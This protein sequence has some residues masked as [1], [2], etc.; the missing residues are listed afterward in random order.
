MPP[1][2]PQFHGVWAQA[3]LD[4]PVPRLANTDGEQLTTTRTRFEVLEPK[5]LTNALKACGGFEGDD[6]GTWVWAGKNQRGDVVTLGI[7]RPDGE[8]RVVLE[9]NSV[10]RGVRGRAVLEAAAGSAIRHAGTTHEDMQRQ[11]KEGLR[12]GEGTKP[13]GNGLPPDV[14]ERLVLD[15]LA[16]YYR[17]WLDLP[18]PA[19]DDRTPRDASQDPKLRGRLID[20]LHELTHAYQTALRGGTPAFDPSWMWDE[21]KLTDAPEDVEHAQPPALAHERLDVFAPGSGEMCRAI[22]RRRRAEPGFNRS[23]T[24]TDEE[25]SSELDLRRLIRENAWLRPHLRTMLDFEIHSRK[26]FWVDGA[27]AWMLGQTDIDVPGSDLRLPFPSSAFVFTDRYTL[28]LAERLLAAQQT[29]P[30]AGHLL[31]VMTVYVT[32][33][34]PGQFRVDLA[35]DALAAD[36]PAIVGYTLAL[37]DLTPV[38]DA[39][40]DALPTERA[41]AQVSN[42]VPLQ[43][44]LQVIVN[45][46]LYATSAGVEPQVR[47][48]CASPS[49]HL[50]SRPSDPV[51]SDEIYYLPG[52]IDI[53]RLNRLRELERVEE[54]RA[55]LHR[56]MVRGHWRRPAVSF[57]DQRLRWIEPYWKGPDMAATIERAYRL[58]R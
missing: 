37:G 35:M 55:L 24:L 15:H 56:F 17:E 33:P 16:R 50:P 26:T 11:V 27:L 12:R 19:I 7:L 41:G 42:A 34:A 30:L 31:R 18:V 1:P 8:S 28:S 44:L 40:R 3:I 43:G 2:P 36:P 47:R 10:E 38:R 4:P 54:G 46:V 39:I 13:V 5:A 6:V 32:R 22:A 14:N 51:A 52:S 58:K 49:N 45:A 53:T 9:T 57:K 20:L 48:S 25:F 23:A 21:L 29:S